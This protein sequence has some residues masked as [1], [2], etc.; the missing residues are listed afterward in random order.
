M[1][2]SATKTFSQALIRSVVVAVLTG[3]VTWFTA[4]LQI[5]DCDRAGN[6]KKARA[7]F[8]AC[9]KR[10]EKREDAARDAGIIA[11]GTLLLGRGVLE[12]GYDAR[13]Q[14]RNEVKDWDV[15]G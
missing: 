4:H 13:R 2:G 8:A 11:A 1:A 12:G 14:R 7:A 6:S 5:D 10:V 3:G 9:E 15:Q